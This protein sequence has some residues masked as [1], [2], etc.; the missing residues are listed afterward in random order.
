[1]ITRQTPVFV[2]RIMSAEVLRSISWARDP[3][4]L[5]TQQFAIE[6]STNVVNYIN[7]GIA[8]DENDKTKLSLAASA[9]KSTQESPP[10]LIKFRFY[11]KSQKTPYA[12]R[13]LRSHE[14]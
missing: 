5:R 2:V 8:A 14:R 9:T 4:V 11:Q 6:S 12:L 13:L 1:M 10:Q 7:F 3:E